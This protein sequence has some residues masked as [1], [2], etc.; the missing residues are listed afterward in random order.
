MYYLTNET[1]ELITS[2]NCTFRNETH[3]LDEAQIPMYDC[4]VHDTVPGLVSLAFTMTPGLLPAYFIGQKIWK[5]SRRSYFII[6]II[7]IPVQV[8]IFPV[9]IIIVKVSIYSELI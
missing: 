5:S 4:L 7:L 1:Y 8:A 9:M 6:F 2:L 3:L